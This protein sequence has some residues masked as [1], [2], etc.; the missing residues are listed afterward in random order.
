MAK[1]KKGA[2][3]TT[4]PAMAPR[5]DVGYQRPPMEHCFQPGQSG[6]PAGRRRG[7]RNRINERFL[8]AL[9]EDFEA[10]GTGVIERVRE[11]SPAVYLRVVAR[12]VPAHVLVQEAR[13]DDLSDDELTTYLLAVRRSLGIRENADEGA[14][15]PGG[16]DQAQPLPSVSEAKTVS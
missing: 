6:N 8:E 5:A 7:S 11:Q 10:H 3:A 16:D 9:C 13:L 14:A 4:A 2:V 15:A 1:T 12:L